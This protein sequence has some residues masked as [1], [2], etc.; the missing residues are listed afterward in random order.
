MYFTPWTVYI[1]YNWRI[2]Y[3]T[4]CRGLL[5]RSSGGFWSV[6]VPPP[7]WQT[8]EAIC[9]RCGH[10][11]RDQTGQRSTARRRPDAG[12]RL[13]AVKRSVAGMRVSA[14]LW[15]AAMQRKAAGLRPAA[16]QKPAARLRPT[17]V[18]RPAAG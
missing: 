18:Q 10:L 16:M 12:L 14:G 1:V 6:T 15:L 4:G 11:L 5:G 17:A 8:E 3:S 2:Y 13:A 9:R 7:R